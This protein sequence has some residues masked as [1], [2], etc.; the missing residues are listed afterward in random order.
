[1][2]KTEKG[3]V[4]AETL[5]ISAL[6]LGTLIGFYVQFTTINKSYNDGFRYNTVNGLYA[7]NNIKSYVLS[8]SFS[9][10]KEA[11]ETND[12][13]DITSCPF[14][15]LTENEHCENLFTALDVKQVIITHE[16]VTTLKENMYNYEIDEAIRNF[17]NVLNIEYL[18]DT[19]RIIVEF[20]DNTLTSIKL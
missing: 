13:V 3:F 11:L 2:K 5:V 1:M 17:I 10:V 9:R 6:V 18:D 19:Y 16:D 15:Y 12:F 20:N 4:L 7:A 14:D 8:S